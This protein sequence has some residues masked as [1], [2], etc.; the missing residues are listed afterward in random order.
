MK[1]RLK[2]G[3]RAKT[4]KTVNSSGFE[5]SVIET[6]E[7]FFAPTAKQEDTASAKPTLFYGSQGSSVLHLQQRLNRFGAGLKKDGFFGPLTYTA[8]R[9][10]QANYAPPVDGIVGPITWKALNKSSKT[11]EDDNTAL[12]KDYQIMSDHLYLAKASMNDQD[13]IAH[14]LFGGITAQVAG[15]LKQKGQTLNVQ[16]GHPKDS[17]K[18]FDA[19]LNMLLKSIVI[20]V[21]IQG[22]PVDEAQKTLRQK[23]AFALNQI[24][25]HS[26]SDNLSKLTAKDA[27]RFKERV[28][29][30]RDF[31]TSFLPGTDYT[32]NPAMEKQ[33]EIPGPNAAARE[34]LV[35]LALSDVGR[36]KSQQ[37]PKR[38][39]GKFL[40]QIFDDAVKSHK[41]D[42]KLFEYYE[43]QKSC[44]HGKPGCKES[45]KIIR[46]KL[47]S[48]CG[49][50]ATY[51]LRQA[52]IIGFQWVTPT[53]GT[54][55]SRKPSGLADRLK[56]R[57]ILEKPK[58]GDLAIAIDGQHHGI[59]TWVD[60]NAKKPKGEYSWGNIS[61]KTVEANIG[62]G[63]I[64]FTPQGHEKLSHFTQ[65][66]FNP[67]ERA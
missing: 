27:A 56:L 12:A 66:V 55:K 62:G 23:K 65:G 1:K 4:R 64:Q 19:L 37:Y 17:D 52:G 28:R 63:E 14:K 3:S 47:P 21:D 41:I 8:V 45:E 40:K 46:D 67:F 11:G 29:L 34:R 18:A 59:I 31:Y 50:G 39:G 44:P 20:S 38:R 10:F 33:D 43:T 60:P 49:I 24:F 42:P 48:W 25:I 5:G 16:G 54:G 36:I 7:P 9:N 57:S 2:R 6:E 32:D 61:I 30:M 51:W 22:I 26:T 15:Q 35:A 53:D 13:P 58:V